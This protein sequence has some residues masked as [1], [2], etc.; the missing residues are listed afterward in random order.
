MVLVVVV[1][2]CVC[3]CVC[4]CLCVCLCVCVC[5]FLVMEPKALH[6]LSKCSPTKLQPQ[7][8]CHILLVKKVTQGQGER[9]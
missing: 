1:V 3:V 8:F 2:G 4:V 9:N 6:M 5:V 7:T